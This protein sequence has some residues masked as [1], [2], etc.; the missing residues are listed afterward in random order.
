MKETAREERPGVDSGCHWYGSWRS[1]LL[2]DETQ[3]FKV[4]KVRYQVRE[5]AGVSIPRRCRQMHLSTEEEGTKTEMILR[6]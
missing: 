6:V 4:G 1:L 2:V 5:A 3:V